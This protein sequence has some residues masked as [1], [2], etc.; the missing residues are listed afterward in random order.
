MSATDET[1]EP[2]HPGEI[3][4]EEFLKPYELTAY[5]L[6]QE[7]GVNASR[8]YKIVEGERSITADTALRLGRFF[9]T[10]AL[11]WLNLQAHYDLRMAEREEGTRESLERIRSVKERDREP[12]E[13]EPTADGMS[14]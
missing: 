14:G 1:Y 6:A 12:R 5:G 2:I 9:D 11:L 7:L 13:H 8:I 4:A 10:T 3:L